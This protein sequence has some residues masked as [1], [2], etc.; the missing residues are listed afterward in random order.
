MAATRTNPKTGRKIKRAK[1]SEGHITTSGRLRLSRKQFALPPSPEAKASGERGSYPIDTPNRAR[2]A[3]SRVA[4]HGSP[5]EQATVRRKVKAK[6]PDI[7]V[8]GKK[9]K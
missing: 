9:G 2:N 6:F 5:S 7:E 4:H 1:E 3:L 8:S